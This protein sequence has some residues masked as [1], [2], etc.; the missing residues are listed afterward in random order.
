MEK[1]ANKWATLNR[2][3]YLV[4]LDNEIFKVC[5]ADDGTVKVNDMA[6]TFGI[7]KVKDDMYIF[8]LFNTDF[9]ITI[10]DSYDIKQSTEPVKLS[11]NFQVS[12]N[13]YQMQAIVDDQRSMVAQ[14]WLQRKSHISK[15]ITLR[16]PMPGLI[17]KVL[18][19]KSMIVHR[20]GV[21]LI[22]EAMKME[23]EIRALQE[24]KIES[25]YVQ[26][27]ATV[28][29]NDELLKIVEL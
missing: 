25:V 5:V 17:T 24:C 12:V 27:G 11:A 3:E 7:Q 1:E 16:A 21:L 20:G 29:R 2:G 10:A 23:N 18:I 8:N 13:D 22:L 14:S 19:N 26:P 28:E 15:T 6:Y 9:E 4:N